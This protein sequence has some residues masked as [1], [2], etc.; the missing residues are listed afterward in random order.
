MFMKKVVTNEE[1]YTCEL[2]A[3]DLLCGTVKKT[4]G[5]RGSNAIIDHSLLSPFITN[6][7]VTI[8][9]NIESDDECVNTILTL[10][11]ESS[12]KTDE[13]V[14]DGTT[15]TLVL[16]ESIFKQG[17]EKIKSGVNPHILKKEIDEASIEIIKRLSNESKEPTYIEYTNIASNA[18]NDEDIGSLISEV[19]QKLKSTNGL[20]IEESNT[21]NTYYDIINGYTFDSLL[22]S[23]YFLTNKAKIAYQDAYF[24]I[25]NKDIF[26]IDQIS[27]VINF[28]ID[29]KMPAVI[30]AKRF[31]EDVINEILSLNFSKTTNVTLLNIPE[32]GTHELDLLNDLKIISGAKIVKITDEVKINNLGK[33]EEIT[34]D[35][36][37]INIINKLDDNKI[38]EHVKKLKKQIEK[39]SDSYELAFQ[40]DR[41]SKLTTGRAIIYVGARTTTEAREKK[42]RFDDALC[43][44]KSASDGIIPGSG[45]TYLK[46]SETLTNK[47]HGYEILKKALNKPFNQILENVGLNKDEIYP[48]IKE[49]DFNI[50]YNVLEE[51]YEYTNKTKVIDPTNVA[52]N[53][54]KNAV[55]IASMLLTTT[56]L[57]INE[58]NNQNNY[59]INQEL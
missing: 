6:D 23:P 51:R 57:I 34:I 20:K 16:L 1:L 39:E 3:I 52:I 13:V 7:G 31:A 43:A 9:R 50:L 21:S 5:P 53:A 36:E 14:G 46:I 32:Y 56:S 58:T 41:I 29:K 54:L 37:N 25:I 18:A 59:N 2:K 19:Y 27:E 12:I 22:A 47:H 49:N 8:A 44:L 17:L 40:N 55:S 24:L 35:K 11:K 38:K 45:I 33:C 4:L 42:M 48:H 30:L 26:D 10:A 28:L 15:T